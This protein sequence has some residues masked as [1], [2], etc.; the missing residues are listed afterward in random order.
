MYKFEK[1]HTII[2]KNRN[3]ILTSWVNSVVDQDAS[4][5]EQEQQDCRELLKYFEACLLEDP[6][7]VLHTPVFEAFE[8]ELKSFAKFRAIR[9][10]SPSQTAN[11]ILGLKRIIT[12][13]SL[14]Y[15]TEV[16][17]QLLL[18]LND[19]IDKIAMKTFE[20]YVET[21]EDVISSQAF[22]LEHD[23]PI[24]KIRNN[25]V[26]MSLMGIIDTVRAQ[27]IIEKLLNSIVEEQA[28]IAILDMTAVPTF[29]THVADNILKTVHAAKIVG[30]QVII[31]GISP[32][33]A[34]TIA[35]LGI[36]LSEI[37]TFNT[38]ESSIEF[39]YSKMNIKLMSA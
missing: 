3:E 20:F 1:I 29:D 11:Y 6:E 26:L 12:D 10:F 4:N 36:N 8:N 38:L 13:T 24:V 28:S 21:R 19:F 7:H 30:A 27:K 37:A 17:P 33:A 18:Q 14:R 25:I 15:D 39:A 35:K 5:I 23:T 2:N 9:E 31:S 32:N 16:E 34:M 22:A